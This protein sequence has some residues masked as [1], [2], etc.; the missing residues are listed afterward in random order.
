M[1]EP[2]GWHHGRRTFIWVLLGVLAI[3]A[4]LLYWGVAATVRGDYLTTVVMFGWACIPL[5]VLAAIGLASFGRVSLRA[6]SDLT[7][8][9]VLPDRLFGILC[10]AG[11]ALVIPTGVLFVIFVPRGEIDIPMSRGM[12]IFSPALM[13]GAVIVAVLG[14]ITAWRR[15][16]VGYLK[17]TQAG[18]DSANVAFTKSVLHVGTTS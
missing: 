15:G 6:E 4:L 13:T 10:F 7:G 14:L 9:R 5:A 11:L 1:P 8:T 12:Q 16:G 17:L 2:P 3:V 18:I